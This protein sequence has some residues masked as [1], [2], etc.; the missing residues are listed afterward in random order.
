M[1]DVLAKL[2]YNFNLKRIEFK[3]NSATR[4]KLKAVKLYYRALC[5]C[6]SIIVKLRDPVLDEEKVLLRDAIKTYREMLEDI[7]KNLISIAESK[8]S[9]TI[10]ETN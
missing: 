2:S 7:D 4:K 8:I 10:K 9:N 1:K 3:I 6:A 5:E